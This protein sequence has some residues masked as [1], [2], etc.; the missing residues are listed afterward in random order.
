MDAAFPLVVMAVG[1]WG[2]L[3]FGRR[4]LTRRELNVAERPTVQT[5]GLALMLRAID[6]IC[7]PLGVRMA[8]ILMFVGILAVGTLSL[9]RSALA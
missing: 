7:G 4:P 2:V 9:V 8:L 3:R 1:C 5:A 6:R